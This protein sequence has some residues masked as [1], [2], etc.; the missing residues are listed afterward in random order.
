MTLAQ[1]RLVRSQNHRDMG[2]FR[3]IK[4][5]C[6]IH[7]NLARRIVDMVVTADDMRDVHE[8]VIDDNG[9]VVSGIAVAAFDDQ[10]IQL[11]IIKADIAF[12]EV[13]HN[14]DAGLCAAETHN[15]AG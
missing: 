7:Q 14:G 5:Q 13:F 8:R 6:L 3:H 4:T 9:K 11:I 12:N 15:A 2:E 1:A 10:I